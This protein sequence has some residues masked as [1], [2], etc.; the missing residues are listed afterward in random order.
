MGIIVRRAEFRDVPWMV[1]KFEQHAK[2]YPSKISLF[3]KQ[4][5]AEAVMDGMVNHLVLVAERDKE[6]L[7]YV[8]G[9]ISRHFYNPDIKVLTQALW[10][11]V[12]GLRGGKAAVALLDEFQKFGEEHCH[13]I[14]LNLPIT[15]KINPSSFEKRGF[16]MTE[17][18]F[19]KEIV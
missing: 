3:N 15:T 9:W 4:H 13:W 8:A 19:L 2:E 17:E 12:P 14:W 10:Y 11:V 6:L 16:K 1:E 7:G 5:A 18:L